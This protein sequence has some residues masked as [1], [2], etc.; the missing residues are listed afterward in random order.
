M[1]E[2]EASTGRPL[3]EGVDWNCYIHFYT[4]PIFRRPLHEGV[5]WNCRNR[6]I[7]RTAD[8]ALFTRAWIEIWKQHFIVRV[9]KSRPLHEGVDWNHVEQME[10]IMTKTSPSSR[11][12]GLKWCHLLWRSKRLFVALFT[13][14]WIEIDSEYHQK[15]TNDVAL[16]TRAW[17]EIKHILTNFAPL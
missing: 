3:H 8:V 17:I 4:S 14:A 11:G 1:Q 16:F 7:P 10:F 13:R 5:D 12:R 2:D 9:P 15:M 6:L